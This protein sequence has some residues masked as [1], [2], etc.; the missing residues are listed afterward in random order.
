MVETHGTMKS[1]AAAPDE[2]GDPGIG[3]EDRAGAERAASFE[4][5][6][7]QLR[8]E[9]AKLREDVGTIAQSPAAKASE[10]MRRRPWSA[11]AAALC[12]GIYLGR[13]MHR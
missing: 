2:I 9:I 8:R 13:G 4:T 11:I 10:L 5:K 7:G 3:I 6:L 12:V 1:P